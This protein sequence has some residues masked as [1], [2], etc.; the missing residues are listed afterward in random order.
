MMRS[1][2]VLTHSR[3]LFLTDDSGVG[4]SHQ[5]PNS[6]CYVVTR[7]DHNLR[8]VIASLFLGQRQE[9]QAEEI[10]RTKGDY[11]NGICVAE[12]VDND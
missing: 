2:A 12:S 11:Q 5:E 7:L 9:P 8:R 3:Y 10:I 4:H 1:L 6:E